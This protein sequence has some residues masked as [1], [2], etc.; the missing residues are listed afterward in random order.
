MSDNFEKPLGNGGTDKI[1]FLIQK[2]IR[3]EK[4]AARW[5]RE[6]AALRDMERRY[7]ALSENP[8]FVLMII[9]GGRVHYLNGRG[10]SFFGF[11]LREHPRFLLADY[12]APGHCGEVDSLLEQGGET[13]LWERRS[14]F[15]VVTAEGLEKWLD[16]A[17][18]PVEYRGEPS[19]LVVGCEI[20]AP[21]QQDAAEEAKA[22]ESLPCTPDNLL[23]AVTDRD[24]VLLSMTEG[25]RKEAASMWQEAPE[26]GRQMLDLLP[27]G[28]RGLPFRLAAEKAIAGEMAE[29]GQEAGEKFFSISFAPVFSHEGQITGISLVLC[30]KTE[31]R[32]AE[33]KVRTEEQKFRRLFS[34][35]SDLGV[36]VSRD[37]GRII[38]C[39][40]AFL[41]R[42]GLPE[43]RPEGKTLED[44]GFLPFSGMKNALFSGIGENGAVRGMEQVLMLPSGEAVPVLLSAIPLERDGR[45]VLLLSLR[46]RILP[47]ISGQP[48]ETV[49]P[50]TDG[51]TD[52]LLGIP[53]REGFG[54]IL[55]AETD[56]A[57][58][59]R[60]S[61]SLILMDIDGFRGLTDDSG[62][63]AGEQLLRD[64]CA[65][66]KSRIHP[67]DFLARMGGGEFAVLTPM[68]GYLA[69]QMADKIR[70][71]VCHSHFIPGRA[72]FCSIG[73][74]EFRREMS[75][76]EFLKRAGIAL[77][78]AKRAGGNR[79]VLAPSVL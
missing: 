10:E 46:E 24:C 33:R 6:E 75:R 44:M 74:C 50:E 2:T 73:V 48:E 69:H 4:D 15:P 56:R 18:T 47:A 65:V 39:N 61:L 42:A 19:L 76:E 49:S 72:V 7:L 62:E 14:V 28:D 79:A 31:Q 77:R 53:D 9:S 35:V 54:E 37:D 36:I 40:P 22:A 38:E 68:S 51:G 64:F 57:G 66:V 70:D 63:E 16:M 12:V 3:M 25:F 45:Q 11:P 43:E 67:T 17:V 27:E 23:A 21:G 26:V 8:L 5:K 32:A 29:I 58:R 30:E 13:E 20:P 52:E 55:S 71:M 78:E 34:L 60:G 41:E 1:D 59:H